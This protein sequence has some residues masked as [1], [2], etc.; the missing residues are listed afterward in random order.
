MTAGAPKLR[1]A[2]RA[3]GEWWN[4]YAART[5]T[6]DG[7]I[8]LGSVRITAMQ[9]VERRQVFMG[10]MQEVLTGYLAEMG[11]QV[12]DWSTRP[13]PEHERSGRA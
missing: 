11:A 7:A 5:A 2:M 12:A 13:A 4:A 8:L 10:L 9:T 1:L 6:M 3:E